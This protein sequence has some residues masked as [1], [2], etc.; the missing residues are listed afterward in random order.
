MRIGVERTGDEAVV[1]VAG[2]I[3]SG[4]REAV[5]PRGRELVGAKKVRIN[6]RAVSGM[7]GLGHAGLAAFVAARERRGATVTI[8]EVPVP[9]SSV[10]FMAPAGYTRMVTS[11]YVEYQCRDCSE[12]RDHLL[13]QA[14]LAHGVNPEPP[15]CS[16]GHPMDDDDFLELW[17]GSL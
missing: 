14:E 13:Y 10:L 4:F 7:E 12:T 3:G 6:L 9:L 2:L 8:E 1:Y 16:A 15:R 17:Q 11:F 5:L